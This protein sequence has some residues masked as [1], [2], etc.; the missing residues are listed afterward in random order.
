MPRD[1][2]MAVSL[3]EVVEA[4]DSCFHECRAY[5]NVKTGECYN[6][7][8]EDFDEDFSDDQELDPEKIKSLPQ[9]QQDTLKKNREVETSGE[10]ILLPSKD[11]FYEYRAMEEFC[12]TVAN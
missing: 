6:A 11:E 5:L 9:W 1:V 10:W 2:V 3:R 7:G 4:I 12:A 8:L